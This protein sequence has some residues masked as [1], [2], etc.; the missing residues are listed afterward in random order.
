MPLVTFFSVLELPEK[1]R[2]GVAVCN[3]PPLV[4]RGLNA[5]KICACLLWFENFST[6]NVVYSTGKVGLYYF[7]MTQFFFNTVY[8]LW[9][10]QLKFAAFIWHF[11]IRMDFVSVHIKP[12]CNYSLFKNIHFYVCDIFRRLL[13]SLGFCTCLKRNHDWHIWT[14]FHI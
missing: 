9:R 5:E 6:N 11:I 14:E 13:I 12:K 8:L 3:N 10:P 1:N 2:K 4:R 7:F